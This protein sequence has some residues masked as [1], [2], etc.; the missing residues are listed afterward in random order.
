MS[1]KILVDMNLP[2][3]WTAEFSLHGWF[4]VHWSSVGDPRADDEVIMEWAL[5]NGHVV[6]THD[7][8]FG[9]LLAMKRVAGPS[10]IQVRSQKVLPKF[11][12]PIVVDAIKQFESLLQVGALVV[13]E[14]KKSRA[15]VLPL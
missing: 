5:Q 7:L 6:F 11:I 3:S 1:L 8:D 9:N 2:R 4:S 15:R 14:P 12:G 13:V 10:V